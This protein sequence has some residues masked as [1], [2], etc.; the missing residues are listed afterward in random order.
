MSRFRT[1]C[2]ASRPT[3][4]VHG[5]FHR[6]SINA[7]DEYRGELGREPAIILVLGQSVL[8]TPNTNPLIT[9]RLGT[10]ITSSFRGPVLNTFTDV[11]ICTPTHAD[12]CTADSGTRHFFQHELSGPMQRGGVT[13]RLADR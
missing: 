4:P 6:D 12:P 9:S 13:G 8:E 11:F 2:K 1:R 5:Y 3:A 10:H 7:L